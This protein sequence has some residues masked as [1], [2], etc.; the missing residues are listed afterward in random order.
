MS[1]YDNDIASQ[2]WDTNLRTPCMYTMYIL[3]PAGNAQAAVSR[4]PRHLREQH[5]LRERGG[6]RRDA[7]GQVRPRRPGHRLGG[8]LQ[9]EGGARRAPAQV[10]PDALQPVL[11]EEPGHALLPPLPHR[12]RGVEVQVPAG[13][14]LPRRSQGHLRC[15]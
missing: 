4:R 10:Q 8:L 14:Q 5:V 15:A 7:D 6:R 2:S 12:S 13:Q 11:G 1:T 9:P 3:L